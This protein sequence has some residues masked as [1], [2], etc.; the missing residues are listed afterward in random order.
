MSTIAT[1]RTAAA[2]A[3]A[4][5]THR[6][7]TVTG[8]RVRPKAPLLERGDLLAVPL[9]IL[10]G[11]GLWA[12]PFSVSLFGGSPYAAHPLSF[13]WELPLTMARYFFGW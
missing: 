5:P 1:T 4:A 11:I 13:L 6:T 10:W 8:R 2:T 9:C 3:N 7:L 12:W